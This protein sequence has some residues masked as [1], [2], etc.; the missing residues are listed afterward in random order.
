MGRE[1][2][3]SSATW[4]STRSASSRSSLGRAPDRVWCSRQAVDN[5]GALGWSLD[6]AEVAA[7]DRVALAGTDSIANRVWQHG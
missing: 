2:R 5:A 1:R 7:L 4:R 3:R 6:A